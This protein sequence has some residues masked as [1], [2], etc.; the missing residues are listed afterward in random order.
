MGQSVGFVVSGRWGLSG[1]GAWAQAAALGLSLLGASAVARAAE[2]ASAMPAASASAP[3][4]VVA[5]KAAAIHLQ[6]ASQHIEAN[7]LTEACAELTAAFE[8]SGD[9]VLWLRI[10]RLQQ[11]AAQTE[12]ARAAYQRFLQ[13]AQGSRALGTV[14]PVPTPPVAAIHPALIEEAQRALRLLPPPPPPPVV[15]PPTWASHSPLTL[16]PDL[17]VQPVLFVP[18]PDRSLTRAGALLLAGGYLPALVMPLVFARTV[19][20]PD[21]PTALMNY[22]LLIPVVGPFVSAI[23][24]RVQNPRGAGGALVSSWSLPWM[25]TS[26]VLQVAGAV[27]LGVGTRRVRV[28]VLGPVLVGAML[29]GGSGVVISF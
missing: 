24:A 2:P 19:G 9:P 16:V 3:E 28:P 11:R 4:A 17:P 7:R 1:H 20:E 25:L 15:P 6:R 14:T 8:Q 26:G 5:A 13:L 18:R 10:G 21:S 27:V 12:L 29:G 22:S 23:A